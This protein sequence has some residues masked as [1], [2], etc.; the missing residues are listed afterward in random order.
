MRPGN[1]SQAVGTQ[2]ICRQ[3]CIIDGQP[4]IAV[5]L[6]HGLY[7]R[8]YQGHQFLVMMRHGAEYGF[9]WLVRA[10]HATYL[11]QRRFLRKGKLLLQGIII[12]YCGLNAGI[13]PINTKIQR[14]SWLVFWKGGQINK[15]S[16]YQQKFQNN[17]KM[18]D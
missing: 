8:L 3:V 14:Q 18:F 13:T 11:F 17:H 9:Y 16:Y 15:N 12:E 5:Q 2:C 10:Q 6:Y 7:F 4:R 1:K